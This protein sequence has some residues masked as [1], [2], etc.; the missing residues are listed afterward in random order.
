MARKIDISFRS[1]DEAILEKMKKHKAEGHQLEQWYGDISAL[2]E[3]M[4]K[5]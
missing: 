2:E 1:L 3:H 4:R 5:R